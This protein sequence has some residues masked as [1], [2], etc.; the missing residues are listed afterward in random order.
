MKETL[1]DIDKNGDGHVDEDEYIGESKQQMI[2]FWFDFKNTLLV[3]WGKLLWTAATFNGCYYL[4][5]ATQNQMPFRFL[6]S[7]QGTQK[8]LTL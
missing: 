6:F 7:W 2:S 1:E 3:T 8:I 4:A 5:T